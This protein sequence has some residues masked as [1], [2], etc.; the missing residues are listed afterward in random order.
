MHF[1]K[2]ALIFINYP[3]SKINFVHGIPAPQDLEAESQ[4]RWQYN[5]KPPD[6]SDYESQSCYHYSRYD[7]NVY[8]LGGEK[9]TQ[10]KTT[11]QTTVLVSSST[12][13][14]W[15]SS[16]IR[17]LEESKLFQKLS[18]PQEA[19]KICSKV[20]KIIQGDKGR[21]L[22]L[23]FWFIQSFACALSSPRHYEVVL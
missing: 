7:V 11:K 2:I 14:G 20:I 6:F 1:R 15:V 17:Y 22:H 13:M 3:N 5:S 9:K 8:L 19:L 23:N 18:F 4:I 10:Q 16:K 21:L 12:G